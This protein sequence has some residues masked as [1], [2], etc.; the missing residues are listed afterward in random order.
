MQS[1]R[2]LLPVSMKS[3]VAGAIAPSRLGAVNAMRSQDDPFY[4]APLLKSLV[5]DG[6][7][8]T[9]RGFASAM[10]TL[11]FLA[12]NE[13]DKSMV[14]TFL[15]ARVNHPK[16]TIQTAAIRGLGDLGDTRAVALLQSFSSDDDS[17]A[18]GKAAKAAIEKLQAEK[19]PSAALGPM[20]GQISDMEK[21]LRQLSEQLETMQKKLKAATTEK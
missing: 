11:A 19:K 4:L 6:G 7:K 17:D 10:G 21:Q 9:D 2:P 12:R 5:N 16:Q 13:D 8:Y 14:R 15:A 20:R 3:V 18:L 1:T